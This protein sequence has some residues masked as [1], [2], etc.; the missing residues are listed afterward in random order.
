MSVVFVSAAS[1]KS[2]AT[3]CVTPVSNAGSTV[4]ERLLSLLKFSKLY[5]NRLSSLLLLFN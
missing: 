5:I 2:V 3:K 4:A 1:T